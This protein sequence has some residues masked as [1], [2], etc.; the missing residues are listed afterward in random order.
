MSFFHLNLFYNKAPPDTSTCLGM[1]F[2]TSWGRSLKDCEEHHTACAHCRARSNRNAV[3]SGL[4]A[5]QF[6][7]TSVG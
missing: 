3:L 1:F 6:Y 2:S 5:E 7:M 4:I